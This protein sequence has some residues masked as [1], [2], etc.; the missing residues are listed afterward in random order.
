MTVSATY[1]FSLKNNVLLMNNPTIENPVTLREFIEQ[2]RSTL[3][4]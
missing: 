2:N 4:Q 1:I 3:C